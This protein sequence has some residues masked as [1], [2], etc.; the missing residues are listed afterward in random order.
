M[1]TVRQARPSVEKTDLVTLTIDGVEVS[2]PKGTLVIRAAEQIGVQIPRF[3]DHPLLD[4]GR[5]LPPVPGR[6]PRRR[7]RPRLPEAAG[8]LHARRSPR[9][10]SSTPRSPRRSPTR[11]SRAIMEFLLINHP[12]DCPVCDKGGECPLQNQAMSNGRG[13]SRFA[14]TQAHLPQAD[15]H[16]R[17]G[18][19][20]PRALRA[21]RPLHPVLRADRRRPVHRADRARRPAAGRHLREGAVR[22]LLLRQHDPDLPGRRADLAR[23]TASAPGPFDLVS[24]PSVC[25][26]CASRLRAAHRPP[27]RQGDCAGS[28]ATTPRSTRSGTATRAASRSATPARTTGSPRRWSAT[29]RPASSGP[30]PGPRRSPS[31][32]AACGRG[33]HGRRA[34]RRPADRRGRLRLQQVRPRRA[35]HQRHRLPGPPALRRG[36]RLPGRARGRHGPRRDLRRPRAGQRRAARR[37]SS[38]RRSRRSCSCGCARPPA[39]D[40]TKVVSIA[41]F[42]SRGLQKMHGTLVRTAPGDE[43]GRARGARPRRRDRPRRRRRDPRRRAAR[44]RRPARCP[45]PPTLAGTT[46]ARLAW[47]PRRA[48]ERGALE[49]GCLPEPAA[50][51]P[52]GRRRRPPGSTSAPCGASTV[53]HD[54]RPRRRRDPR[55]RR[56][57]RARRRWSSAASTPPT[58]PTRRPPRAALDAAGFVVSLEV[59]ASAVTAGAPTWCFP[60]APVAEK[61]GTFV[62][63]EGRVRPVREGAARARTRCPTCGCWPASP[64]RWASTSGFRTVDAGPRRDA[65]A[66]RLGRRRAPRSTGRRPPSRAEHRR[67]LTTGCVLATWKLLLD[68]GR[69]LDGDDYLKATAR[70]A[71]RAGVRRRRWPRSASPPASTSTV[72][73]DR[74]HGRRC[75]SASPTS[76]T[77]WCG[78]PTTPPASARRR[79]RRTTHGRRRRRSQA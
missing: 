12:L 31:R 23:R 41:P 13:E 73:G 45:R 65:G 3:C 62:D 30:R 53:P 33:R 28:P 67:A 47:V 37:A 16:L 54:G 63:W 21:L 15:Q 27:P 8:L 71:G 76:P 64:T 26:H 70:A 11:R 46:G 69:M 50:R 9:A 61:A 6:G 24:T 59:R 44:H 36:G 7:Q 42:T 17:A 57:R 32:P 14:E 48:G 56:R 10:W 75:R 5:R 72:T 52:S 74:G 77:V 18:A 78:L 25:E 1:T 43:A 34:D 58:C 35:R 39:S 19:A 51:R 29:R 79:V 66:R 4:A 60:V 40:G 2:V 22:V 68:D 55:R 38:P 49:A 20:R